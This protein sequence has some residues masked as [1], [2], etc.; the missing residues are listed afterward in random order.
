M[1]ETEIEKRLEQC[2]VNLLDI[3]NKLHLIEA[4]H[5]TWHWFFVL[6]VS[7]NFNPK[8]IISNV[9]AW[10]ADEH[11]SQELSCLFEDYIA[12]ILEESGE[13]LCDFMVKEFKETEMQSH[14]L[15]EQVDAF[16]KIMKY[17][18]FNH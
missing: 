11:P 15:F 4:S 1:T 18:N 8:K 6:T 17:S 3:D 10:Q 2:E 16:E 7:P 9:L 5:L 12:C 13:K 14:P